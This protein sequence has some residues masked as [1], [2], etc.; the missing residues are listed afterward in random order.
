MASSDNNTEGKVPFSND[1]DLI[2]FVLANKETKKEGGNNDV[3]FYCKNCKK[4]VEVE[5]KRNRLSFIC[6]E[7]RASNVAFGIQNSL[8]N[9]YNIK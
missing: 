2:L 3:K 9:Y 8:E 4:L 1:L 7:C 6:K 5:K